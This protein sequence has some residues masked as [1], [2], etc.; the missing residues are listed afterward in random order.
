MRRTND[1]AI[2]DPAALYK[3]E[4]TRNALLQHGWIATRPGGLAEAERAV[5]HNDIYDTDLRL[6]FYDEPI[7]GHYQERFDKIFTD[8]RYTD[9]YTNLSYFS[10][11]YNKSSMA[12]TG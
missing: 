6:I 7:F 10:A 2:A 4:T 1:I 12:A 8:P 9:L 11:L 5:P 3:N